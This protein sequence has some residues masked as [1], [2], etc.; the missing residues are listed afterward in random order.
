M[1][2]R[3]IPILAIAIST[4]L[5]SAPKFAEAKTYKQCV[6][7]ITGVGYVAR[8]KWY[9]ATKIKLKGKNLILPKPSKKKK[10]AVWQKRRKWPFGRRNVIKVPNSTL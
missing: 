8:V 9:D 7:G 10:V 4:I 6:K 5:L 2:N 1:K 3:W